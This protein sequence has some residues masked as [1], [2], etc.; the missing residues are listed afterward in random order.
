MLGA[1]AACQYQI[2][3][4]AIVALTPI[5]KSIST[6]HTPMLA[7]FPEPRLNSS[8]SYFGRCYP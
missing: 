5:F 1:F 2:R 3:S 4:D 6:C 7:T 8:S